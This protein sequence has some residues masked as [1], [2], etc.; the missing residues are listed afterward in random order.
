ML[1][2]ASTETLQGIAGTAT[3]VTYT[4]SG[5]LV[6]AGVGSYKTLAQGQ[7]PSTA[8]VLYTVTTGDS[9]L[10][11]HMLFSN[12]SGS[13]VTLSL[14]VNGTAAANKIVGLTLPAN[15]SATF[16]RD[17]WKVYDATGAPV[18]S[19]AT[20]SMSIA[21]YDSAGV[22]QQLLG[23][24]AVQTVTG[25]RITKRVLAL[26][27]NSATPAINSDSYDAVEITSQTTAITSFTSGLTG[28]PNLDDMLLIAITGTAAV[29]LTWG[30]KFIATT[31]ALPTTTVSTTRLRVLF[32]YST[33]ASAWECV[34]VA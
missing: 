8:G 34:G 15:G 7:L 33:A 6:A 28:T 5:S 23:I 31:I 24:S 11:S 10:V 12:S 9:A 14:Y 27:A 29:A 19:V 25:K 18:G 4:I 2:L 30:A 26:S 13:A 16:D 1:A 3:T 22:N 20:G 32:M 21:T 17:G